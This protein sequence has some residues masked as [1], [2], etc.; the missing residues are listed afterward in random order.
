MVPATYEK[1]H[2][3][4]TTILRHSDL[5]SLSAA[6]L[7]EVVRWD[8]LAFVDNDHCRSLGF[9]VVGTPYAVSSMPS[10]PP[11]KQQVCASDLVRSSYAQRRRWVWASR[12][13]SVPRVRWAVAPP[14]RDWRDSGCT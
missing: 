14:P 10:P 13:V 4:V 5:A 12:A 2:F 6:G 11:R 1:Q 8:K 7:A 9:L 3:I